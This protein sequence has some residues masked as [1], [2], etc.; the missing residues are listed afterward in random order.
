VKRVRSAVLVLAVA[1]LALAGCSSGSD[2]TVYG[3][4]FTFT[5]PGGLSEF[6]YP[7]GKRQEV[8]ALSGPDL[9]GKKTISVSDYRGKVVVLNFWGS[10][11]PPCRDEAQGLQAA[12]Q[13]YKADTQFVGVDVK[14]S[15]QDAL[16]FSA[17][18]QITYPS[19]FDPGMRTMLSVRGLPTIGLP[20]TMVLDKQGK[21]AH[22]WLREITGGD[23]NTV[24]PALASEA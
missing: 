13:K 20:I 11:C 5:S 14:D 24:I 3:G 8:G 10:W 22:I 21:V 12:S 18:K 6:N 17:G 4:S 2:A 1:G 9:T 23:L 19:I 15:A 16:A 7:I